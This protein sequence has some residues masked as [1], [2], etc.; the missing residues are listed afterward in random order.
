MKITAD[1][2]FFISATQWG[3]SVAH[4]LLIKLLEKNVEIFTTKEILDEFV[5][6]LQRDFNYI[7]EE[8]NK[9]LEKILAFVNLVEPTEKINIIK[10]DID[11]NKVLEC[12][13]ES[14]S[15]HIVTYD[16]HLLNL[17][18][19]SSDKGGCVEIHS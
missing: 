2:N 6:V 19:F 13:I 11:D 1:T 9:I 10:D 14:K 5:E 4:K 18:E 16:K 3:N 12:A 15:E 7:Q 8:T 17:K